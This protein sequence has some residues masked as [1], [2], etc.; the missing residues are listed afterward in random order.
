MKKNIYYLKTE[1]KEIDNSKMKAKIKVITYLP[2]IIT[3]ATFMTIYASATILDNSFVI[4][5]LLWWFVGL[6]ILGFFLLIIHSFR[7]IPKIKI[8]NK[9]IHYKSGETESKVDI[10]EIEDIVRVES[11]INNWYSFRGG[12][13]IH[14]ENE[15]LIF[16][17]HVY[18]NEKQL[19]RLIYQSESIAIVQKCSFS[20]FNL[21]F[22][23]YFYRNLGS[24][25]M[26]MAFVLA[27]IL[28]SKE[29]VLI[30]TIIISIMISMFIIIGF[31][32]SQFLKFENGILNHIKPLYLMNCKYDIN[33][34]EYA[35]SKSTSTGGNGRLKNLTIHLVDKQIITLNA[36]LNNQKTINEL[37]QIINTTSKNK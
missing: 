36:G 5:S 21:F 10:A 17:Y 3:M 2:T 23:K 16:P 11:R 32:T 25:F 27:Y 7:K 24:F 26:I 13:Q 6:V 4:F 19:L 20:F 33:N 9:T 34:I 37:A 30:G 18:S 14:S 12:L 15:M 31:K 1:T 8:I 29:S 22:I 28:M 35:N